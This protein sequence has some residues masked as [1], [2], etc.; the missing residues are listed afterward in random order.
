MVQKD[1][2]LLDYYFPSNI[3]ICLSLRNFLNF[4]VQFNSTIL[5]KDITLPR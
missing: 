4:N 5:N 2:I 3:L 1:F